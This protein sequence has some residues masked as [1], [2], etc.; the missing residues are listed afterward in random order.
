LLLKDVC[1]L[2]KDLLF[3]DEPFAVVV[4]L[5]H[6]VGIGVLDG[7]IDAVRLDGIEIVANEAGVEHVT[8]RGSLARYAF[9]VAFPAA[10]IRHCA[11]PRSPAPAGRCDCLA[12]A[13][14]NGLTSQRIEQSRRSA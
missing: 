3:L 14:A 2:L 1:L 6:A 8:T 4:E 13:R 5:H 12:I 9:K 10:R 11:C 7:P